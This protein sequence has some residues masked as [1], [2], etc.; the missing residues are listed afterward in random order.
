MQVLK[1]YF[2]S[3]EVLKEIKKSLNRSWT[4]LGWKT[5]QFEDAFKVYTNLKYCH[6][7]NSCSAGLHLA[8]K[9]FKEECKWKDGDEIITT[10]ITFVSTNHAILYEKLSPVFC[11]VDQSL[12]LSPKSVEKMISHKTKAIIYVGIGGNAA[13]FESICSLA[14]KNNLKIILDAAHMAGTLEKKTNKQVGKKADCAI[15]SFQ[16]VKNLPSADAGAICFKSKKLDNLARN[17]SWL[18][19]NKDTYQRKLNNKYIWDYEVEKLGY[20]YHGNSLIASV[21][22]VSLKYLNKDN[23][24]R[25]ELSKIY[26]VKLKDLKDFVTI[27]HHD[28]KYLSSRHLL[29]V[30]VNDRE[31]LI[32]YLAKYKIF[33]GVHYKANY[34]YKIFKKYKRDT[35]FSNQYSKKILSLPL[36]LY[37]NEEKINFICKKI[38]KFYLSKKQT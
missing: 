31:E 17:L 7:L 27:I 5:T 34:Y 12:C 29:Q 35:R 1:P 21:C 32:N 14:K 22:L 25:R 23:K 30:L 16:S 18:G 9:I 36:N 11:D 8:I 10:G 6:F 2:R 28:D 38:H 37:I 20:K 24:Y 15:F 33:C 3:T 13:N 26:T 4:G 19:I